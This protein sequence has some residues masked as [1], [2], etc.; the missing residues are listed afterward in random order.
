MCLSSLSGITAIKD[1]DAI[2]NY[3]LPLDNSSFIYRLMAA[4]S[5]QYN[6]SSLTQR[7]QLDIG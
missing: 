4:D 2:I 7:R 6:V 1:V 5:S 3:D